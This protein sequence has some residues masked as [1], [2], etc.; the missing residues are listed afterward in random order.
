MITKTELEH[1]EK[2]VDI[3]TDKVGDI[4]T[5][6]IC[7]DTYSNDRPKKR[8][9]LTNIEIEISDA[10]NDMLMFIKDNNTIVEE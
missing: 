1:Y 5:K 10:M 9:Y 2:L 4:I 8:N 3:I 7:D 6:Y